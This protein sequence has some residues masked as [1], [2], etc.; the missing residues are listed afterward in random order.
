M[1]DQAESKGTD[2]TSTGTDAGH[3]QPAPS[4]EFIRAPTPQAALDTA[5]TARLRGRILPDIHLPT[6]QR[7][8]ARLHSYTEG[9][10]VVYIVPGDTKPAQPG[11]LPPDIAEHR[12]YANR[13]AAFTARRITVVCVTSAPLAYLDRV[14]S[15]LEVGH[16][17]FS[18]PELQI[19]AA[20]GLPVLRDGATRSY[21]RMTLI[22]KDG[23]ITQVFYPIPNAE[24][25]GNARQVM[26][27]LAR[28]ETNRRR[29]RR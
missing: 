8:H 13:L 17:M 20:L 27:F 6:L 23:R 28:V 21:P 12:G 18:D 14:G 9:V 19:A 16:M 24:A 25:A 10:A 2:R 22:T 5:L 4:A 3:A 26:A 11:S 7:V 15:A 1:S 29:P